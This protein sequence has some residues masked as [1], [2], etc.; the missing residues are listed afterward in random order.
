MC[1]NEIN[2]GDAPTWVGAVGTVFAIGAAVYAGLQA[3]RVYLIEKARDQQQLLES[4]GAQAASISAWVDWSHISSGGGKMPV[5]VL[6]NASRLPV[7]D[8]RVQVL[9]GSATV[10]ATE[11]FPTLPPSPEP[12]KRAIVL[13][14]Q[15]EDSPQQP[16]E[17]TLAFR[18]ASGLRWTRD[19]AGIIKE[20][21]DVPQS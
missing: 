19:T 13:A 8:L 20:V 11:H 12:K 5:V 17:V 3:K 16:L 7:Y 15:Q 21:I 2:W 6:Q 18:D 14:H 10:L 4:R 9:D 1:F